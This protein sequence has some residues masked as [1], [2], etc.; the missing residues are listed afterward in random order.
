MGGAVKAAAE[1]ETASKRLDAVFKAQGETTEQGVEGGA[2]LRL[3]PVRK[4]RRR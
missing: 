2:G 1:A 3:G 4:D